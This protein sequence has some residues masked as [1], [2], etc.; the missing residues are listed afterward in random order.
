MKKFLWEPSGKRKKESLLEDFSKYIN[1]N[2]ELFEI[3]LKKYEPSLSSELMKKINEEFK[4]TSNDDD[5]VFHL[6]KPGHILYLFI[7][8]TLTIL[9]I[10]S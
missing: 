6:N 3:I 4:L 1:I 2:E 7:L 10:I 9:L 5:I 8:T